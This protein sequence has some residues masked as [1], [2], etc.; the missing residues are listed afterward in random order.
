MGLGRGDL[1][2]CHAGGTGV[3]DLLVAKGRTRTRTPAPP[4]PG[5][6]VKRQRAMPVTR[7]PTPHAAAP[8]PM[9]VP[10]SRD[11]TVARTT[12]HAVATTHPSTTDDLTTVRIPGRHRAGRRIPAQPRDNATAGILTLDQERLAR[13]RD[14][15]AQ[16]SADLAKI[17]ADPT[18]EPQPPRPALAPQATK[19]PVSTPTMPG[20]SGNSW[21]AKGG[22][23]PS[24]KN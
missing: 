19:W 22:A 11:V 13:T 2:H 14:E 6:P 9:W 20:C 15:S 10:Q 16:V 3:G 7:A 23:G 5:T 18:E 8:R 24:S 17:F 21:R 4:P 1:R 12:L